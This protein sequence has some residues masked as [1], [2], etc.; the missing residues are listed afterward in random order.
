M[1][2]GRTVREQ[3]HH[4][5]LLLALLVDVASMTDFPQLA[6]VEDHETKIDIFATKV[7]RKAENTRGL[8]VNGHRFLPAGGHQNSPL[9]AIFSP[10][11]WP[12][13]L[14]AWLGSDLDGAEA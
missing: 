14:P 7:D 11:W 2:E 5:D 12:S 8:F 10:R 1:A 6:R 4:Q 3:D 9:V 13:I